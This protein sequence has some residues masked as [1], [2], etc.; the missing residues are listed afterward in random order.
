MRRVFVCAVVLAACTNKL[1]GN[2]QL[3]GQPF[4]VKSCRSGQAFG[5]NG[6]EISDAGG[7]RIRMFTNPDGS[8]NAALFEPGALMGANLGPCGALSAQ[9]QSSRINSIVNLKGSAQ[10]SCE[11]NGHKLAGNLEFENCH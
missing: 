1:S 8:T 10:L 5:F 11:L 9:A 3:D 7:R 2:L 4:A 6:V